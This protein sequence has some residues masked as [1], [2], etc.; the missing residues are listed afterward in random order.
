MIE[1]IKSKKECPTATNNLRA[2]YSLEIIK[3]KRKDEENMNIN[4]CKYLLFS[5]NVF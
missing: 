3:Q 1:K 2:G 4:I 5:N